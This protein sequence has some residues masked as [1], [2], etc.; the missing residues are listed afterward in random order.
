MN[1][2][3][4]IGPVLPALLSVSG[5]CAALARFINATM[6]LDAAQ[7]KAGETTM[8]RVFA[9]VALDKLATNARETPGL[10]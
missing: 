9:Q 2:I 5:P 3:R 7:I 4:F 10:C 6:K 1:L 8:W